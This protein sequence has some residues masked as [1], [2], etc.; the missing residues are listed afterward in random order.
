M[1]ID[2]TFDF[3]KFAVTPI[4][5]HHLML[6]SRKNRKSSNHA[7][8]CYDTPQEDLRNLLHIAS[9]VAAANSKLKDVKGIVMDGEEPLQNSFSHIFT[10]AQP[11]RDFRHFRQNIDNAL[12]D[13]GISAKKD[14]VFGYAENM[15][16]KGLCDSDNEVEFCVML[17]S[18]RPLWKDR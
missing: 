13:L 12:N 16:I 4:T 9:R 10:N 18:F 3:G 5:T 15:Y 6:K 11:L 1:S 8:T 7:W 17:D 14:D 2:P